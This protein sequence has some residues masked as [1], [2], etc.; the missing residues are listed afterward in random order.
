MVARIA[1][2]R[3]KMAGAVT[4][5]KSRVVSVTHNTLCVL[6]ITGM[7]AMLEMI[8]LKFGLTLISWKRNALLPT[9]LFDINGSSITTR[10]CKK[11]LYSLF[12]F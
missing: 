4:S 10:G 6:E 5:R 11:K 7:S 3:F 12:V 2:E 9:L 8:V 1:A